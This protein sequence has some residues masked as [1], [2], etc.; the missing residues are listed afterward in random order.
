NDI[1]IGLAAVANLGIQGTSAGTALKNMYKDLSAS[2]QKVTG[3]LADM[4]MKITDFR[5]A[6]GF[7]LP[8]VDVIGKLN[9]GLGTLTGQARNMA[10]V[11]LFGQQGVRE[12]AELLKMINT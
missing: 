2:T 12:G 8:L 9:V 5:D 6:D 3:T 10:M 4:H 11:K 7:M 1:A